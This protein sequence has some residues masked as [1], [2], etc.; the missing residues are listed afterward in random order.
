MRAIKANIFLFAL[1]VSV[2]SQQNTPVFLEPIETTKDTL[3]SYSITFV[4]DTLITHSAKI[5]ITF[6][7]EFDPR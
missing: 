3:T 4:S 6:P 5:R 2:L 1:V 7:F